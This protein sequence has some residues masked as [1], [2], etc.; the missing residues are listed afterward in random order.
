M[1]FNLSFYPQFGTRLAEAINAIRSKYDPT[2]PF[3]EPHIT[4]IFPTHERIG[5]QNLIDHI[6]DILDKWKP[7]EIQLGGLDLRPNHWL[8]LGLQKGK[9]EIKRLYKELHAGILSDGRD[10]SKYNPHLSLGL[11]IKEGTAHDWFNPRESDFDQERYQEALLLA[12]SLPLSESVL[13]D[14]FLLGSFPDTVIEWIRGKRIHIPQD[15]Q[16]TIVHEFIL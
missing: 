15:A 7:F 3:Y 4:V 2:S 5:R 9:A 12:N 11:F 6:Q 13:I 10:L 16:E 14:K 1:Y 8:L